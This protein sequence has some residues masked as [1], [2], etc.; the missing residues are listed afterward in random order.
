[1]SDASIPRGQLSAAARRLYGVLTEGLG[2]EGW[3]LE[4]WDG[5]AAGEA[6]APQFVL[7]FRSRA[8]LDR[9][10]G[11]LPERGFGRAYVEGSLEIEGLHAFLRE[12]DHL[13]PR[14]IARLVPRL[15]AAALAMGAR[16]DP[17]D[18]PVEARLRG[19]LHSRLRD[20]EAIRHHY[21][22][23][24][25]F[26][27]LFLGR[28]MTY[29]CAYFAE[30]GMDLDAAQ[31]AKNDL[32]CRKLRLRPGER[33]LDIGCGWGGLV[34]QAA[35]RWGARAVG[36]TTSPAQ[37]AWAG[38]R[39]AE[40]GL[41]GR[42]EIRLADW[43]DGLGEDFDAVAS[44]GMVEHVGPEGMPRYSETVRSLLRPGGRA[45]IH[46]ITARPEA[47]G[48]GPFMATFVFPDGRLQEVGRM[49]TALQ[50]AG[51]EVRDVESLREHYAMTLARWLEG[52]ETSWEEAVR[53]VGAQRARVWKL[54]MSGSR[55]GFELGS[56]AVHQILAVRQGVGGASGLP[57]TRAD[58]YIPATR[59]AADG[60]R[61]PGGEAPRHRRRAEPR[62]SPSG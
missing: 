7:R 29:S 50:T 36:I 55:A 10:I 51:L 52:L 15:L 35:Q 58:W 22:Q 31:E 19:R 49:V 11:D 13:R 40:L 38:E 59:S 37:A 34:V 30:P 20:R 24:A 21:D 60:A 18:L 48:S 42:A 47:R 4:L 16:P 28:T 1:M 57:L 39:V 17:R 53:I 54:Y 6:A 44:V 5:S 14:T 43:R 32:V 25:S 41:E 8:G 26:Y 3:R 23:P 33:L 9:L 12:A 46:G 27:R 62:P 2:S 56:V 45:L 61:S